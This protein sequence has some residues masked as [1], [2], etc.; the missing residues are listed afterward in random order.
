MKLQPIPL[1]LLPDAATVWTPAE[2]M[3]GGAFAETPVSVTHVRYDRNAGLARLGYVL[4]EGVQGVLYVDAKNSGGAF[5]IPAGSRVSV[6][7]GTKMQAVQVHEYAGS[8]GQVHH[9]EIELR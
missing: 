4:T 1:Y 9:W 7:G 6:N 3:F 8:N 2:G 5:G